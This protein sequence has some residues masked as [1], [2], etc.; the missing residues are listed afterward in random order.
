MVAR[1][2]LDLYFMLMAGGRRGRIKEEKNHR[3]SFFERSGWKGM[4][5]LLCF[6]VEILFASVCV[7]SEHGNFRFGPRD[8]AYGIHFIDDRIG[9]I[10]GDRGLALVTTNGGEDWQRVTISEEPF[11]DIFFIGE[12]GWIVGDGGLILHTDNGGKNWDKQTS[13][14]RVALLQ[15]FFL[16]RNKGFTV[17]VDGTIL[18]TDNGGSSWKVVSLDWMKFLPRDLIEKG[19]ISINLYDIFFSDESSGWI[20]GDCGTVLYTLDGGKIWSVSQIGFFP[21]LFS[22]FFK[23]DREGWAVG[24]NGFF[25]KT[26]DGGRN[27]EKDSVGTEEGLYRILICGD[28]GVIVGDHGVI[29]KT[30]DGGITW[31]NEVAP[32]LQP[33]FPWL[34]DAW[35]LIN[36]RSAKVFGIGK[37]VIVKTEIPQRNDGGLS[38]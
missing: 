15:V 11:K 10:A 29:I 6:L 37:G 31:S 20:V 2:R 14:V 22:V 28:Y 19:V 16:N 32:N 17:G 23:N 3:K 33:P 13:D 21:S 18:K 34:A 25:L 26:D 24:Q 9:W 30:N 8:N 1:I 4:V 36:V 5:L 38:W 35:I 27:W 12:N 7:T